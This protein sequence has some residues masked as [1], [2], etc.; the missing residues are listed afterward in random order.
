MCGKAPI[1]G[2]LASVAAFLRLLLTNVN[3]AETGAFGA[4]HLGFS[5]TQI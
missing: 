4:N 2:L 5:L 3:E 1:V